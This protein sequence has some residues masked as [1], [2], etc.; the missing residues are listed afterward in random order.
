MINPNQ[1]VG[2]SLLPAHDVSLMK[3]QDHSITTIMTKKMK[4]KLVWIVRIIF[5]QKLRQIHSAIGKG[6]KNI[7]F[8]HLGEI[9]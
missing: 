5:Y 8:E 2:L 9:C 6:N 3:N 7:N 4:R 1:S